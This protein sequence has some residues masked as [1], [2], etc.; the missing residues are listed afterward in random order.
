MSEVCAVSFLV[1]HWKPLQRC[2]H[3]PHGVYIKIH[4]KIFSLAPFTVEIN[5]MTFCILYLNEEYQIP[6]VFPWAGIQWMRV[7]QDFSCLEHRVLL[8]VGWNNEAAKKKWDSVQKAEGFLLS[9]PDCILQPPPVHKNICSSCMQPRLATGNGSEWS[10]MSCSS[11]KG[12]EFHLHSIAELQPANVIHWNSYKQLR[13][14]LVWQH[15]LLG[16]L[17]SPPCCLKQMT[18]AISK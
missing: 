7:H 6:K 8:L 4:S 11:L 10:I 14:F 16:L 13:M 3:Q 9:C 17:W 18:F 1:F 12:W 2:I 5:M 15:R